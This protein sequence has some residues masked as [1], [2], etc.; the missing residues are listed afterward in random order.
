MTEESSTATTSSRTSAAP[1]SII[2]PRAPKSSTAYHSP[3]RRSLAIQ[4]GERATVKAV[5]A[6]ISSRAAAVTP[7]SA[8]VPEKVEPR[9]ASP[10]ASR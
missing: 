2:A 9:H 7:S 4:P 5:T 1:A 6:R 8:Q 3:C 10:T